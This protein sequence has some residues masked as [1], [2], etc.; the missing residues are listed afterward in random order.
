MCR[1]SSVNILN[2]FLGDGANRRVSCTWMDRCSADVVTEYMKKL[3]LFEIQVLW[4]L[5]SV[6]FSLAL[7]RESQAIPGSRLTPG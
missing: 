6:T 7:P 2:D 1:G 3:S 4:D 5:P